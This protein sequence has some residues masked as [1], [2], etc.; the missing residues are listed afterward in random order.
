MSN[1]KDSSFFCNEG[2]EMGC[3]NPLKE[4]FG[5]LLDSKKI[6]QQRLADDLSLDKAYISRIVNGIEIPPHH[7]RIK[8]ASYFGVDSSTIWRYEDLPFIK[9]ILQKQEKGKNE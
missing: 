5:V 6:I 9:K 3:R 4:R 2:V 8:I 1:S 7:L